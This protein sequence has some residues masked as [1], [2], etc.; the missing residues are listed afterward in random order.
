MLE[1][2][3]RIAVCVR[4]VCGMCKSHSPHDNL[5]QPIELERLRYV[6][7]C[8]PLL[9]VRRNRNIDTC[10]NIYIRGRANSPQ[11]PANTLF[12]A[13][14]FFLQGCYACGMCGEIEPQHTAHLPHIRA[15]IPQTGHAVVRMSLYGSFLGLFPTGALCPETS[16]PF[17]SETGCP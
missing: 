5:K 2:I 1:I 17:A 6:A 11:H 7:V 8:V 14:T 4:Y 15:N 3:Q 10:N 16:L 12:S 13:I 9:R